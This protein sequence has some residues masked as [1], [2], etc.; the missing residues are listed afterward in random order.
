MTVIA[1]CFDRHA[2]DR[3]RIP[4]PPITTGR[5][6]IAAMPS[7]EPG[8][9][10]AHRARRARE[11]PGRRAILPQGRRHIRGDD[12]NGFGPNWS[13][14]DDYDIPTVLRKQMD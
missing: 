12:P 4:A 9:N 1:T 2:E 6:V 5:P 13:N 8:F 10:A 11:S 3:P 14:V 7:A